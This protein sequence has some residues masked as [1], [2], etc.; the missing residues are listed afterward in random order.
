MLAKLWRPWIKRAR[1]APKRAGNDPG[2]APLIRFHPHL[3]ALAA[4]PGADGGRLDFE[5]GGIALL[6]D[7]PDGAGTA[8]LRLVEKMGTH[9]KS[10]RYSKAYAL[11]RRPLDGGIF[12]DNRQTP[13]VLSRALYAGPDLEVRR[14]IALRDPRARRTRARIPAPS[15]YWEKP[16]RVACLKR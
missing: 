13:M 11:I 3:E 8:G 4:H 1:R 10:L 9:V 16:V 14:R 7:Q 6:A 2:R 12:V 5:P 15:P